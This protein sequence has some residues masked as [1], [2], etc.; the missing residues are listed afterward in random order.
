M[1]GC[2]AP[3]VY[4][5]S[6]R[7]A[8]PAMSASHAIMDDGYQLPFTLWEPRGESR[9]VILALHG[10]NDY[11]NAFASFGRYMSERGI[12]VLAYDQRGFGRTEGA[13]RWHG[14]ERL[15]RDLRIMA[16]LLRERF[17][18]QALY[19]LGASMGGA[20]IL[21]SQ[22]A[23]PPDADGVILVAPAVWSRDSMPFYQRWALW[24]VA[25]TFPDMELSGEGLDITPSDNV[26][27]LRALVRDPL[28]IKGARADVVYGVANLMDDAAR[29]AANLHR[30][31]LILYGANDE[32]IPREPS[33]R[34]FARLPNGPRRSWQGV[35]YDKGYHMLLRDLQAQRVWQDIADWVLAPGRWTAV[36]AGRPGRTAPERF[37]GP[38]PEFVRLVTSL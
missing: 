21:A 11:S 8:K 32:I 38:A 10:M 28:V 7:P 20:V 35:V 26:E 30:N 17:T 31:A 16:A 1:A 6:V 5:P 3:S 23:E 33:C 25:H 29:A 13:G 36:A 37:C 19:L 27:M 18:G 34:L 12:T 15:V 22:R 24:L 2:A 14:R 4:R 9:A